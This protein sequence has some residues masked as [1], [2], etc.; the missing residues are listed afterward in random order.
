MLHTYDQK[1]K[2]NSLNLKEWLFQSINILELLKKL[3]T[4]H[5]FQQVVLTLAFFANWGSFWSPGL[6]T[7]V[8]LS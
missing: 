2:F 1:K 8:T 6:V 5:C 3:V 7:A 4:N